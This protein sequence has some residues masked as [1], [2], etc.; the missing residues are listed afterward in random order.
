MGLLM[1]SYFGL[2][3]ILSGLTKS[4]GHS[5]TSCRAPDR[6]AKGSRS[7]AVAWGL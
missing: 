3:G 1:A 4:T 7:V 6:A 5:S 2:E